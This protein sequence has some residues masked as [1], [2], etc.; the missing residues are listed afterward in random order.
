[1]R[2][3][4]QHQPWSVYLHYTPYARTRQIQRIRA[5][6][7][8]LHIYANMRNDDLTSKHACAFG[9]SRPRSH[10]CL[11]V[12]L[13]HIELLPL[14]YPNATPDT[15]PHHTRA[16]SSDHSHHVHPS[17]RSPLPCNPHLAW[18]D[19]RLPMIWRSPRSSRMRAGR[20][21]SYL[22]SCALLPSLQY[23]SSPPLQTSLQGCW[24]PVSRYM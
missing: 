11:Q 10:A 22:A 1:M 21:R 13:R 15:T 14:R 23:S 24:C 9:T 19:C 12:T 8:A 18:P 3:C 2:H 7:S 4:I 16:G 17:A 6:P 5:N 20:P